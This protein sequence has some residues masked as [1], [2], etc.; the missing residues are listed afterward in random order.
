MTT[1]PLWFVSLCFSCW[2]KGKAFFR[3]RHNSHLPRAKYSLLGN[4]QLQSKWRRCRNALHLCVLFCPL[5][6]SHMEATMSDFR[7]VLAQNYWKKKKKAICIGNTVYGIK[8]GP[9]EALLQL[10]VLEPFY[11]PSFQTICSAEEVSTGITKFSPFWPSGCWI[12]PWHWSCCWR[13]STLKAFGCKFW[14]QPLTAG[15]SHPFL[16]IPIHS[17]PFPSVLHTLFDCDPSLLQDFSSQHDMPTTT[18]GFFYLDYLEVCISIKLTN[19]NVAHLKKK[20]CH[21]QLPWKDIQNIFLFL[22]AII[23]NCM[24]MLL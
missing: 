12:C 2:L 23:H 7:R 13:S 18:L 15:N 19:Y 9:S 4:A 14:C 21:H 1:S 17:Q 20:T 24:T 22:L 5:H 8:Y 3:V 16:S 11:D 6:T 10:S